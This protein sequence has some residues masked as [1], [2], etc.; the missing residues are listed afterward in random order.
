MSQLNALGLADVVGSAPGVFY[1]PETEGFSDVPCVVMMETRDLRQEAGT[2][3]LIFY[4]FVRGCLVAK[5]S[6]GLVK[7]LCCLLWEELQSHDRGTCQGVIK[8]PVWELQWTIVTLSTIQII[9]VFGHVY[10]E[11]SFYVN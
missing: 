10:E 4:L 11:L 8:T 1:Y 7:R 6:K 9:L 2:Y 3:L 5:S